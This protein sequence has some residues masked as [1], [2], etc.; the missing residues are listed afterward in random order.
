[1]LITCFYS[2]STVY[3]VNNA[4]IVDDPTMTM[5]QNELFTHCILFSDSW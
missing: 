2:C 1:M 4:R 3:K 5:K